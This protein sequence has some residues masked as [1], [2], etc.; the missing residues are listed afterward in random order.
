VSTLPMDPDQPVSMDTDSKS[1]IE[2]P[3][4]LG[5]YLPAER[6]SLHAFLM[7]THPVI[8][9]LSL[10][11]MLPIEIIIEIFSFFFAIQVFPCDRFNDSVE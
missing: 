7:G 9:A 1:V 3:R 4:W 2:K 11:H 6:A 5:R 10:L 8:G